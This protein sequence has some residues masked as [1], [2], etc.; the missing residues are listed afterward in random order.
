VAIRGTELHRLDLLA[1]A[2][3]KADG[4]TTFNPQCDT[5][6]APQGMIQPAVSPELS[7]LAV[8]RVRARARNTPSIT[9]PKT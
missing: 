7:T 6:I 2:L 8:E 5:L 3:R 4:A 1:L 9:S